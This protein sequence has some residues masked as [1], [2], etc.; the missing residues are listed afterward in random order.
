VRDDGCGFDASRSTTLAAGHF[1]WLGIRER[2]ERIGGTLD[3]GSAP[4]SGTRVAVRVRTPASTGGP[5]PV[6]ARAPQPVV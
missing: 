1:G 4:G 6:A 3:V 5:D 2:A